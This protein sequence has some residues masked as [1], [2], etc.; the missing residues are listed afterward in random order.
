MDDLGLHNG[1]VVVVVLSDVWVLKMRKYMRENRYGKLTDPKSII[2]ISTPKL[3]QSTL[4]SCPHP[5][6]SSG[7]QYG[8]V[9]GSGKE[10]AK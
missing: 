2:Y 4:N 8:P 3:Q 5:R 6:I 1:S 10:A 7:A 9:S